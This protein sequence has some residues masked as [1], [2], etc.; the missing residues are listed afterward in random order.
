MFNRNNKVLG[1]F[2]LALSIFVQLG[3][4]LSASSIGDCPQLPARNGPTG[5]N[6]LRPDDIK[7]M[8]AMGDR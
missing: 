1:T 2:I 8:A 5:V 3:S 6:D 4:S 7:V